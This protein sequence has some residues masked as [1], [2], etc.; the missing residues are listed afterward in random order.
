MLYIFFPKNWVESLGCGLSAGA[1]YP[2]VNTV[3]HL[4]KQGSV[5]FEEVE[6]EMINKYNLLVMIMLMFLL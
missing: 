4:S 2:L 6:L 1:A 5:F 3:Q